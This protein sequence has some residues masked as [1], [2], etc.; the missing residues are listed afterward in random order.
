MVKHFYQIILRIYLI[1]GN[2]SPQIYEKMI[3][4]NRIR[5]KIPLFFYKS[6]KSRKCLQKLTVRKGSNSLK[7]E[8]T[9]K[10]TIIIEGF[11]KLSFSIFWYNLVL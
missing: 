9:P 10:K 11:S 5:S 7:T 1:L 6:H 3:L 4:N 2:K 8:A